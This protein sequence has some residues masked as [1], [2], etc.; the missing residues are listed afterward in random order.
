VFDEPAALQRILR[1]AGAETDI[2]DDYDNRQEAALDRLA[3]AC[4]EHL[5]LERLL[6]LLPSQ[7]QRHTQSPTS[8]SHPSSDHEALL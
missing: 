7:S 2:Q 8:L 6:S 5:D 1:W 3:D 4:R